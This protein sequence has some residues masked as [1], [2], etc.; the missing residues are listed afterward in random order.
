MIGHGTVSFS[1]HLVYDANINV[2]INPRTAL[3][4]AHCLYESNR[5]INAERVIAQLGKH[6]GELS[7]PNTQNFKYIDILFTKNYN[8]RELIRLSTEVV[9]TNFVQPICLWDINRVHIVNV[10]HRNG[11]VI[12]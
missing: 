10:L 3:T 7:N 11:I 4:A 2:V 12:G 5:Q 9:F 8:R 6:N 1:I